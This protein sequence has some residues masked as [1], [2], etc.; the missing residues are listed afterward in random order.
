MSLALTIR[1]VDQPNRLVP[2]WR[3]RRG[4][5]LSNDSDQTLRDLVVVG[6]GTDFVGCLLLGSPVARLEPGQSVPFY[7]DRPPGRRSEWVFRVSA[8][9]PDGRLAV[10]NL[11]CRRPGA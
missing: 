6:L 7:F 2:G 10:L 1:P 8:E 4:V 5:E 3:G 9:L 11:V